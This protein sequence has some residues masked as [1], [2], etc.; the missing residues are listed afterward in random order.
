MSHGLAFSPRPLTIIA[1]SDSYWE[2]T[3]PLDRSPVSGY[4]V[5]IGSIPVI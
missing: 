3:D 4:C 1:Y 5:F 2:G